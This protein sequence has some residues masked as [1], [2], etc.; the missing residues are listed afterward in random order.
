MLHRFFSFRASDQPYMVRR[1]FVYE[2]RSTLT[3][4]LAAGLAEGAF[5]GIV[6]Q[7][8]FGGGGLLVAVIIAAPMFGNILA[9]VWAE[10]AT[11]RPKVQFVNR[12]QVGVVAA[13]LAVPLTALPPAEL[14]GWLFA[15][16]IIVARV[17]AS[18]IVTVRSTIWRVNYP[19][20]I[21]GQVIGRI[22]V[23]QS[24]VLL[25][26]TMAGAALI[27]FR[28]AALLFVYPV[29]ALAGLF[30]V[31]QFAKVRVRQERAAL[32]RARRAAPPRARAFHP[33]AENLAETDES[34]VETSVL[35]VGVRP[36]GAAAKLGR[37]FADSIR[38]LREDRD[39]RVYQRCQFLM[40]ASF[41]AMVPVLNTI[42]GSEL[43]DQ[44]GDYA[45]ANFVVHALPLA[46][47]IFF[48]PLWAPLFDRLHIISYRVTHGFL[49]IATHVM[50]MIGVMAGDLWLVGVGTFMQGASFAGGA[51]AWNLGQ[52]DFATPETVN[53]YMGV[54]VM[55]TGARGAVMPF[56]GIA[57]YKGL[58][59]G[60]FSVPSLGKW[61]FAVSIGLA[62]L[63]QVGFVQEARR[64]KRANLPRRKDQAASNG[65]GPA[66]AA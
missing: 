22:Q 64:R 26:T 66:R 7:K 63:S 20:H 38:L 46:T 1:N 5:A 14:G 33:D 49:V 21:R 15:L 39:F 60:L 51:L 45:V 9:L 13:L 50:L 47:T 18:G 31:Q 62:V 10:M 36:L 8:Y 57:L 6:A 25:G 30:G 12:L 35:S 54:H 55:L 59:L 28:P 37:T 52:N 3:F 2:L 56:V 53:R 42:V 27:D 16:L 41:M 65:T 32:V 34:N 43:T 23:I 44:G 4:P 29:A 58:D 40:G 17:L 61:M 48:T 24:V 19:D 11:P